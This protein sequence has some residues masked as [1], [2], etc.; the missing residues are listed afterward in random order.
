M[1]YILIASV[2]NTVLPISRCSGLTAS[3]LLVTSTQT[4]THVSTFNLSSHT[5]WFDVWF[6]SV[7]TQHSKGLVV[8]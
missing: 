2:L 7:W 3:K 5:V 8:S 1:K 6:L 4:C